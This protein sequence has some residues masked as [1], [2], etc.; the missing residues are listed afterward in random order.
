MGADTTASGVPPMTIPILVEP[1]P[2]GY[3]ATTG[4]P[5]N[6]EADAPTAAEAV[7]V[8]RG[9]LADRV[10]RGSVW[11]ELPVPAPITS[12]VL[13][14]AENPLLDDWL[15]AVE[16]YRDEVDAADAARGV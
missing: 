8:V 15:R 1:T 13:P 9:Q 2:A 3:R 12:H 11:L 6:L 10:N 14:L 16:E 4:G 7:A 5:L